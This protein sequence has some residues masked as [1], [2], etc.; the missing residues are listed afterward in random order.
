MYN[1]HNRMRIHL[2]I[3]ILVANMVGS[4]QAQDS[5]MVRAEWQKGDSRRYTMVEEQLE[6]AGDTLVRKDTTRHIG[7]ELTVAD[8]LTDT[9]EISCF[10]VNLK[11][12]DQ[13]VGIK[14]PDMIMRLGQFSSLTY[15]YTT[16]GSGSFLA[17]TTLT[18]SMRSSIA[19][20][21]MLASKIA[22]HESLVKPLSS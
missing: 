4:L 11:L 19:Y 21:L 22:P 17:S 9:F 13:L 12:F 6:Y 20:S 1:Q 16:D 2:L 3:L 5:V 7:M 15:R 10:T 18:K 8:S 14:D